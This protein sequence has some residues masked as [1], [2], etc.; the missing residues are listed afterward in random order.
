MH[1]IMAGEHVRQVPLSP[2]VDPDQ[3]TTAFE[4]GVLTLTLPKTA[5]SKPKQMRI[6]SPSQRGS[7]AS[8]R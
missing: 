6:A 2:S 4:N 5:D 1:V 7:R 8:S 3:A